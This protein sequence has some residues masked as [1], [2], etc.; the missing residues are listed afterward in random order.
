MSA[1]TSES[2]QHSVAE[3]VQTVQ[4]NWRRLLFAMAICLFPLVLYFLLLFVAASQLGLPVIARFVMSNFRGAIGVPLA[5]IAA[6]TIVVLLA[7]GI[8]GDFKLQLW[9]L[10]LQGPSLPVLL[11]VVCFLAIVFALYVLFTGGPGPDALSDA[12]HSLCR[13]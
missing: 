1:P 13:A 10:S 9:G 12:L 8:S 7:T 2:K 3:P 4:L 6:L 5:I 11:W